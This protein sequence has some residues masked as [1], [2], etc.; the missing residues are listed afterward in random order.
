MSRD[1]SVTF[2]D[3]VGKLATLHSKGA[4]PLSV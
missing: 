2:G 1:G 3:L 4:T